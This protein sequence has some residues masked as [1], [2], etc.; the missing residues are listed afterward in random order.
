MWA[1]MRALLYVPPARAARDRAKLQ[2]LR[3]RHVDCGSMARSELAS[4]L[5]LALAGRSL[6]TG[7]CGT[8]MTVQEEIGASINH[9]ISVKQ[10]RS[11]AGTTEETTIE[12]GQI[13]WNLCRSDTFKERRFDT[14][15]EKACK[16]YMKSQEIVDMM[17]NM[18][19]DK[20]VEDYQEPHF[21]LRM[22]RAVCL[23]EELGEGK[24]E[25]EQLPSDYS[26]LKPDECAVCE[27]VVSDI[28]GMVR[29]SRDRPKQ[30]QRSDAFMRLNAR[31]QP[32]C[33]ELPMRHALRKEHLDTIKEHCEDLWDE[34]EGALSK[35]AL[36]RSARAA[37]NFCADV[38]SVCEESTPRAK[39]FAH[40]PND[41]GDYKDEV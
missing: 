10:H 21:V 13:I 16:K 35:L 32:V 24:C 3:L 19:K 28:F 5:L 39:L 40:E 17:T 31:F 26:P 12:I 20:T 7:T 9:N 15:T 34:H 38:A 41:A 1:K 2:G 23:Q 33:E 18:W 27:A 36:D 22:K 11:M 14:V 25:P 29:R 8:C 4:L 37:S 30:G 6:A